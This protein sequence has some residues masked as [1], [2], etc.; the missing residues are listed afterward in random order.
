VAGHDFT[1]IRTLNCGA[2]AF[3]LP[4]CVEFRKCQRLVAVLAS[5]VLVQTPLLSGGIAA[6]DELVTVGI[7][8]MDGGE[9]A[10]AFTVS[11]EML[12]R[13]LVVA[14]PVRASDLETVQLV[15]D[16]QWESVIVLVFID[17]LTVDRAS[18]L[19]FERPVNAHGTEGVAT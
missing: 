7:R 10:A 16:D 1:A 8:A 2:I 19:R 15:F 4:V 18:R 9:L 11:F 14:T 3:I 12:P 13:A 6:R 5:S 17:R